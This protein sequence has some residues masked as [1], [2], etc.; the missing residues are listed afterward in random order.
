MHLLDRSYNIG[1]Q[2]LA[3]RD[4]RERKEKGQFLTPPVIARYMARQLGPLPE[5]ARVLDPAGGSG[6]LA[7]AVIERAIQDQGPKHIEFEVFEIDEELSQAA[8]QILEQATTFAVRHGIEVKVKVHREDF[9]LAFTELAGL[10]LFSTLSRPGVAEYNAIIANPPYFKLRRDDPRVRTVGNLLS[11][12][13]NIY[14]LFMAA[15]FELLSSKGKATFI[16]PRSFCSGAYFAKFRQDLLKHTLP[17]DIHLFDLRDDAF[18]SVLQENLIITLQERQEVDKL[19][20]TLK[21]SISKSADD[22]KREPPGREV[23]FSYF[24]GSADDD[25]PYF[26]L[27]IDE[28]DEQ[29]IETL[30]GWHGSLAEYHL[31]ISTGPIVA[32]RCR[33]LL[34]DVEAVKAGKAV[35]LYWLRNVKSHHLIWPAT[36]GKKP[37]GIVLNA[38]SASLLVPA[39]NYVVLRRFSAKEEP[40]RLIVAPFLRETYPYKHVGLE[41]HLNYIYGDQRELTLAEAQG[42]AAL[43]GSALIDRYIRISNGNTQVN[44]AELRALPL[45]PLDVIIDIG[46]H[47]C[48]GATPPN[49]VHINQTVYDIL[50][51]E[52]LL[53]QALPVMMETRYEHE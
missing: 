15:S 30:E 51:A 32:F 42:L 16:V 53:P 12:H 14:T 4:L 52:G 24:V 13:T 8:R 35:P 18:D 17:T 38:E 2:I 22:L 43:L 1:R 47:I 19:P 44:A 25:T 48:N 11:G 49:L 34:R 26:R 40:R 29:I 7:C 9:L 10:N 23:A 46:E 27:P 31:Q 50:K 36:R 39:A 3:T 37:Q 41:N 28:R 6:V 21:I 33:A 5:R 20:E 45:P